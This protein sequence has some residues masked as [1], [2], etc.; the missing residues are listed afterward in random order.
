MERRKMNLARSRKKQSLPKKRQPAPQARS[1]A[2]G[3][4]ETSPSPGKTGA[5]HTLRRLEEEETKP[6]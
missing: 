2:I 3:N 4:G 5:G 1:E 6:W